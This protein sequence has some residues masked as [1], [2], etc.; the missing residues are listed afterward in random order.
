MVP[1]AHKHKTQ[2]WRRL[3]NASFVEGEMPKIANRTGFR[4]I[5]TWFLRKIATTLSHRQR[6][7][8][9][10]HQN[11]I[12]WWIWRWNFKLNLFLIGQAFERTGLAFS[13]MAYS[14]LLAIHLH[15]SIF[16]QTRGPNVDIFLCDFFY[17]IFCEKV[18]IFHLGFIP[19]NIQRN[20]V[21][22]RRLWLNLEKLFYKYLD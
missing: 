11:R 21:H 19:E 1:I 20:V 8:H 18:Q 7:N 15:I 9:E 13:K 3:S 22:A 2:Q 5:Q 6:V 14:K 16:M 17:G 12:E 10:F 4:A